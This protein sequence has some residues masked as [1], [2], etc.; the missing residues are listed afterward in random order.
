MTTT[1]EPP[2][3]IGDSTTAG[4]RALGRWRRARWPLAVVGIMVL[5]VVFLAVSRPPADGRAYA[6]DNAEADGARAVA[7]VLR[8]RGVEVT[9]VR[10]VTEAVGAATEGTTLLV[11]PHQAFFEPDQVDALVA[12]PADLVLL[13][14]ADDLLWAA[15]D[16]SV[17]SSPSWVE[18]VRD[19]GCDGEVGDAVGP[20]AL[21]PGLEALDADVVLC[22]VDEDGVAV[23]G[24]VEADGRPVTVVHDPSFVRNDTVLEEGNA[25]LAL[26]TLGENDHLVW[27]V[28]DPM[29]F[30]GVAEEDDDAS[31]QLQPVLPPGS[32]PVAL[33]CL[34]A[35]A[36]LALWRARRLGPL[37]TED[38]PVLVRSAE[39]TRGRGRLYRASRSRGHA[40]AGLRAVAADRIARRL[41]LARSADA[42]TVVDAVVAATNRPA[43][44]VAHLLYGP[45]P[46]DDAALAELARHLDTLESEVH[47]P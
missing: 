30:S 46:A 20:L 15:T 21:D 41:G 11:T 28:P 5:A 33:V 47:R 34:L 39:T 13:A 29:D 27:F 7:E 8:N 16:G 3:I 19:A 31:T 4:G 43:E 9:Y 12:T 22:W 40:A 17:Q 32:A 25:A 6:P 38:L 45:P 14:P 24:R 1:A 44:Q 23:Y 2:V 26:R 36:F 37:V 35:A 18:G 42:T 10:S